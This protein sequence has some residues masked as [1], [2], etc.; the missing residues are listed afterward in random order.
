MTLCPYCDQFQ[1]TT[2]CLVPRCDGYV[3]PICRRCNREEKFNPAAHQEATQPARPG[4]MPPANAD[5]YEQGDRAGDSGSALN[6]ADAAA[7]EDLRWHW[8][9]AYEINCAAGTWT[10]R[11]LTDTAILSAGS[12]P[13]LRRLIRQDRTDRRSGEIAELRAEIQGRAVVGAG[14][15]ALRRLR[16]DGRH[17]TGERPG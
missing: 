8:C 3:C 1:A 10:A 6:A 14:E 2:I 12:E 13:E 16:D 9:E 4:E 17:L 11:C 15:L 5:T 7:L